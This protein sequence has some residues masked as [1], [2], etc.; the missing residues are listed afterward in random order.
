MESQYDTYICMP[1][2]FLVG[3]VRRAENPWALIIQLPSRKPSL[4]IKLHVCLA[5][6]PTTIPTKQALSD[7]I[8]LNS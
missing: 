6:P 2:V 5:Q 3:N 1:E 4:C 8:M 7:Y